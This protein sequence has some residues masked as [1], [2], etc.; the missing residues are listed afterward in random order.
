M[1]QQCKSK[2]ELVPICVAVA[3]II[4]TLYFYEG[5]FGGH[6]P[7]A[8]ISGALS[9]LL[10]AIVSGITIFRKSVDNSNRLM[11]RLNRSLFVVSILGAS[12]LWHFLT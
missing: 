1:N 12:Y 2:F 6:I 9:L 10:V 8:P 5:D 4:G 7:L 3:G 11:K